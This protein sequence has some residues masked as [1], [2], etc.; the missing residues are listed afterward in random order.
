MGG[1]STPSL[2]PHP[3]TMWETQAWELGPP[4]RCGLCGNRGLAGAFN[5]RQKF[6]PNF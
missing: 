6:P 5:S 2:P 3:E 4:G 1:W